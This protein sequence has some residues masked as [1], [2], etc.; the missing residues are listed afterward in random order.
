MKHFIKLSP[1]ISIILI[2]TFIGLASCNSQTQPKNEV[3][4]MEPV[5]KE[6]KPVEETKILSNVFECDY[7]GQETPGSIPVVFAPGI[8]STNEDIYGFEIS[9]SGKEMIYTRKEGINI[10]EFKSGKWSK[11]HIISFSKVGN[12]GECSYS[13]DGNKIYFNSRRSCPGSKTASNIWIS[14]KKDGNWSK[15]YYSKLSIPNKTVHSVSVAANGNLYCDGIVR[16][17]HSGGSYS[18]AKSLQA[19]IKGAHVFIASDESYLMFDKRVQGKSSD[20]FITFLKSDKTWT[21]PVPLD[22]INTI[23][24]ENQP[25][26]TSD[27]KYIFFTRNNKIFWMKA[28]FINEMQKKFLR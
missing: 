21:S 5:R 13:R 25:T 12:N 18:K 7:M 14:E 10:L 27:G 23:A 15:P 26:V 20:I 9:P 3:K 24:K 11:P 19:N 2:F 16:F 4:K 1:R 28:D 17:E 8:V 6:V 22:K